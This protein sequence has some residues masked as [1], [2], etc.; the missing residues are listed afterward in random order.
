MVSN[1]LYLAISERPLICFLLHSTPFTV[2]RNKSV[3]FSFHALFLTTLVRLLSCAVSRY[4]FASEQGLLQLVLYIF[5]MA[6]GRIFLESRDKVAFL[7]PVAS[8]QRQHEIE[9]V[10]SRTVTELF[11]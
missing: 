6:Q 10:I 7:I 1:V 11:G 9:N 4:S 2:F 8:V 3:T 5:P